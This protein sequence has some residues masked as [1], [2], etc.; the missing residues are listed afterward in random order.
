MIKHQHFIAC[1]DRS[2]T[3]EA[4]NRARNRTSSQDHA[5]TLCSCRR[6]IGHRDIHGAIGTKRTR[7][8]EHGDFARLTQSADALDEAVNNLGLAGLGG[9][10]INRRRTGFNTELSSVGN[11]AKHRGGFEECFSWNTSTVQTGAT[12]RITFN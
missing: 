8:V 11:M 4:R 1:H 2:T 3:V 9:R 10:K 6:T 7:A 12:E 5:G